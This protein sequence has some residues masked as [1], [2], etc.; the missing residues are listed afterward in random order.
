MANRCDFACAAIAFLTVVSAA[1]SAGAEG[2]AICADGACG[3]K[4][5]KFDSEEGF[6]PLFNGK[7]FSGWKGATTNGH[8]RIDPDGTLVCVPRTGWKNFPLNLWTERKYADFVLRFRFR[9]APNVN[10]GIGI[11][12]PEGQYVTQS[13]LE[14]QMLEDE[15]TDYFY[16]KR[17]LKPYQYNCSV[18]GVLPA[19]RQSERKGY[20]RPQGEWNEEEIRANGSYL[21]VILNGETVVSADLA[22]ID[23]DGK[24]PDGRKHPGLRA[25][26]GHIHICWH[27]GEVAFRDI[28][29]K[30][31]VRSPRGEASAD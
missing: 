3:F 14:I 9:I 19:K 16:T 29:I 10:N 7:D 31:L 23:A 13:G 20:L 5:P 4:A 18:Y 21:T 26:D 27:D 24:T 6:R 11:R 28:R 8:F 12:A 1:L 22:K 30:E 17:K 25:K 2:T 15:S